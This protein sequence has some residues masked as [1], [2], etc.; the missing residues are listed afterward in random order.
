MDFKENDRVTKSDV[1]F[2]NGT[3][4]EIRKETGTS[5]NSDQG[6]FLVK[7]FW[8]NGTKSYYSTDK[9]KKASK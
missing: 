1:K 7:V 9:L 8:D 6:T 4:L 2:C 5:E 3:I